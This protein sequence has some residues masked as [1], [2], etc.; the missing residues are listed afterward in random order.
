MRA[1]E[2]FSE[3]R[4]LQANPDVKAAVE[5]GKLPSGWAHYQAFGRREGR[6]LRSRPT[7]RERMLSGLDLPRMSGLEIGPLDKPLVRKSEGNVLY[8]DHVDA[9]YLRD[10]HKNNPKVNTDN[11]VEIDGIW[12]EKTLAE[13]IGTEN[14]L[15][16]VVASHV[17][18]H[19]PDLISWLQ[20]IHAVLKPEGSLRLAVPDKRYT[21]DYDRDPSKLCDALDAYIRK[22]RAPLPR[23]IL[24]FFLA[25]RRVDLKEAWKGP[26]DVSKLERHQ[27]DENALK[28]ARLALETGSYHDV[29]C[30]VFT[31]VSFARLMVKLGELELLSFGCQDMTTTLEN[32][33]EFYVIMSPEPS[34]QRVVETWKRASDLLAR[35]PP[36]TGFLSHINRAWSRLREHH[37]PSW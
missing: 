6:P 21:F 22:A 26:L 24:D 16:Y 36:A 5:A 23:M 12:G 3:E 29:H 35:S 27:T 15:D 8:V 37:R 17:V 33:L 9:A 10:R 28:M 20:E 7:R 30:W 11:I 14:K 18:E 1:R 31:P 13:A 32:Q 25:A 34:R 2:T 19:V 4:Y